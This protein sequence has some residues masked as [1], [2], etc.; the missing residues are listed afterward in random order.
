MISK[1]KLLPEPAN[2]SASDR[3]G[4]NF[5]I[6]QNGLEKKENTLFNQIGLKM[7]KGKRHMSFLLFHFWNLKLESIDSALS[8]ATSLKIQLKFF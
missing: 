7:K 5:P 6:V 3:L 4:R 8:S 2:F 1:R